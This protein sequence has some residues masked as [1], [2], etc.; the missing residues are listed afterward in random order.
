MKSNG[1]TNEKIKELI[2]FCSTGYS[3]WDK[4]I[5]KDVAN[6]YMAGRDRSA[7][8]RY[9]WDSLNNEVS[10]ILAIH[11]FIEQ[12][13]SRDFPAT[14]VERL[15]SPRDTLRVALVD[16]KRHCSTAHMSKEIDKKID[17]NEALKQDRAKAIKDDRVSLISSVNDVISKINGIVNTIG[18]LKTMR[19]N[20]VSMDASWDEAFKTM[21]RDFLLVASN[22][23]GIFA[24]TVVGNSIIV[25][26]MSSNYRDLKKFEKAGNELARSKQELLKAANQFPGDTKIG[27][28]YTY[29]LVTALAEHYGYAPN[30]GLRLNLNHQNLHAAKSMLG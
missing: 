2:Q 14:G 19:N 23:F 1:F 21:R 11:S 9:F 29:V 27:E 15:K 10:C 25:A 13:I 16:Y 28:Y 8:G 3:A 22:V 7:R 18:A 24:P 26:W 5:R 17:K 20:I 6:K 4:V 12:Y 30:N